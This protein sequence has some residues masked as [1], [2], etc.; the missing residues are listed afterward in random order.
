MSRPKIFLFGDQIGAHQRAKIRLAPISPNRWRRRVGHLAQ[1]ILIPSV[2]L[3]RAGKR[4]QVRQCSLPRTEATLSCAGDGFRRDVQSL[5]HQFRRTLSSASDEL[6]A[7]H[8]L[9]QMLQISRYLNTQP[10]VSTTALS[11]RLRRLRATRP[12][13]NP[14]FPPHR[15]ACKNHLAHPLHK[16]ADLFGH[17]HFHLRELG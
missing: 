16:G 10:M 7:F 17:V 15:A 2:F 8:L 5:A 4:H 11:S 12:T 13:P 6:F 1:T 9:A 14:A 3:A